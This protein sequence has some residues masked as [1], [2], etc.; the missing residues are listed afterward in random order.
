MAIPYT[1]GGVN[2]ANPLAA[3]DY[4]RVKTGTTQIVDVLA[5]DSTN[6][7]N[8]NGMSL[9]GVKLYSANGEEVTQ[10]DDGMA[11]Y[12]I[13]DVPG[14]NRQGIEITTKTK[15]GFAPTIDYAAV[16]SD[17]TVSS[18]GAVTLLIGSTTGKAIAQAN[19]SSENGESAVQPENPDLVVTE[20]GEPE[21]VAE[22]PEFSGGVNGTEPAIRED[23]PEYRGGANAVEA[24]SNTKSDFTGGVNG[25]EPAVRENDP[26]YKGSVN[27]EPVITEPKGEA[28]AP[29]TEKPADEE[30]NKNVGATDSTAASSKPEQP[31][32]DDSGKP[33]A[34]VEAKT[35]H[36]VD[37]SSQGQ[38]IGLGFG[39]FV[40]ALFMGVRR[41]FSRDDS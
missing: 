33:N 31:T 32:S 27:G 21:V 20:K 22:N 29:V 17:G 5:N 14:K 41:R 35:G 11:S 34:P 36:S 1:V 2:E 37:S 6:F 8:N 40:A 26:E 16:R 28:T 9:T 12:R 15:E 38:L 19:T 13:V 30:S 3:S 23:D 39:A 24:D 7:G 10:Y 18:K 25:A 4:P